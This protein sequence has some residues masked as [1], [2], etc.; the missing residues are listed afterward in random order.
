LNLFVFGEIFN[1]NRT[2]H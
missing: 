1:K 2:F